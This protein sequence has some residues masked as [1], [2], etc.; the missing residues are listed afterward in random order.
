M[1]QTASRPNMREQMPLTAA[2]ITERR[3]AW[4]ATHVDD[5][6]KRAL[7]GV[8]GLFYA[9]E[10]GHVIGTPF[11]PTHPVAADQTYAVVMGCKF[12][13]FMKNPEVTDGKN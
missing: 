9:L 4:G 7:Q 3:A 12:A 13:V 6:L 11:P 10:A 1:S 5:C 2:W 8:P